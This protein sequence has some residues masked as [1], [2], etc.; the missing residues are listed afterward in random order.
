MIGSKAVYGLPALV[1]LAWFC[2]ECFIMPVTQIRGF[3]FSPV[4]RTPYITSGFSVPEYFVELA[5]QTF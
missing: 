2:Y 3:P 5:S 1:I 4:L